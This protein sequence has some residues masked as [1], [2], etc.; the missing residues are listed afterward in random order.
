MLQKSPIYTTLITKT[1]QYIIKKQREKIRGV[2]LGLGR[3]WVAGGDY[4]VR[5]ASCRGWQLVIDEV[6]ASELD[7]IHNIS[8]MFPSH[9]FFQQT[10]SMTDVGYVQGMGFFSWSVAS[11]YVRGKCIWLMVALLKGALH[12]PM[13]GLYL[14][15]LP[16]VQQY[17]RQFEELVHQQMPKL[18]EHFTQ[19]L[20]NPSVY[21]SQWFITVF[22]CT[23]R[24]V[25]I[26]FQV[27]LALLI[28][29]HS[30][31]DLYLLYAY[32]SFPIFFR[33]PPFPSF[34]LV[35]LLFVLVGCSY[36]LSLRLIEY[37]RVEFPPI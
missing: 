3:R 34:S 28:Y 24:G 9:V 11:L 20:I 12:A 29:C 15:G 10:Q 13:E 5:M 1:Y 31:Y 7:I 35:P 25:Q 26:V 23:D 36:L 37:G 32:Y 30:G 33:V 2:G 18:G 4:S 17:L 21:A 14:P 27:Q 16:F 8:R 19:E 22:S 6:S